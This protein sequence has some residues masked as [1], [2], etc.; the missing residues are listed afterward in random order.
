[1]YIEDFTALLF[2]S[3]ILFK[4]NRILKLGSQE[5]QFHYLDDLS[6]FMWMWGAKDL[7]NTESY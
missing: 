4:Y 1:M 7:F 3:I 2:P 6:G 5:V